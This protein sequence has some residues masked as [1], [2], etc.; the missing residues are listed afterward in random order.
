MKITYLQHSGFAVEFDTF[1]V[2]FD[3]IST[4]IPPLGT[5]KIYVLASHAHSDHFS[6]VVFDLANQYDA[7]YILSDDISLA[8]N[9]H[10]DQVFFVSEGNEYDFQDFRLKTFGST[11]MGLSFYLDTP[12][13]KLFHSGDLHWW[14]W[15]DDTDENNLA[16]EKQYKNYIAQL[17]TLPVDIAFVPVDPRLQDAYDYGINYFAKEISPAIIIPMH[18]WN[19]FHI[20]KKL[21]AEYNSGDTK[22]VFIHEDNEVIYST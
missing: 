2:L 18:F 12:Q 17:S 10:A 4:P 6:D 8:D 1:S 22:V 11:D 15:Y 5:K 7:T 16:M 9:D 14:H 19:D 13:A 3:A 20:L 21:P